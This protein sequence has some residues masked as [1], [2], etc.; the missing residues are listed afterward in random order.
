MRENPSELA[1]KRQIA[2]KITAI[3]MTT[4]LQAVE[5]IDCLIASFAKKF[6]VDKPNLRLVK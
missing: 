3:L 2:E 6:Q 1:I 4:E 5:Q